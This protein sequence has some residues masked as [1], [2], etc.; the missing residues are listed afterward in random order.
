MSFSIVSEMGCPEVGKDAIG[1]N[2]AG[3][4][5]A[6]VCCDPATS[7][8]KSACGLPASQCVAATWLGF[9]WRD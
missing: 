7:I 6:L 2:V 5:A 9:L 8:A 1:S 3:G 4:I